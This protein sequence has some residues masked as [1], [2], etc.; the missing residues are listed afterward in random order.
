M[1]FLSVVAPLYI[2]H[3][4]STQKTFLEGKI[5]PGEFTPVNMKSFSRHNVRKHREITSGEKYITLDIFLKFGNLDNMKI[6]SSETKRLFGK[7]IKVVDYLS[8][9]QNYKKVK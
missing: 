8:L 2:Y 5:T 1:R 7:I 6:T 3:R 9:Y 4:C